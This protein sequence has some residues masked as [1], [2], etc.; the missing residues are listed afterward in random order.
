MTGAALTVACPPPAALRCPR[1]AILRLLF[2]VAS[3]L[4]GPSRTLAVSAAMSA[5]KKART[6]LDEVDDKGNFQRVEAAWRSQ[7]I[8]PGGKFE[9]EAG[10]YHLYIAL[11]CPWAAGTLTALQHKGLEDVISVSIAH[12][13][14]RRTRPDDPDDTHFG[15]WFRKP[16]DPPVSNEL[17][18]GQYECDEALI[19]DTVNH[20][21]N[22]R[23]V[24]ELASDTAGKY[25][26]PVLWCKKVRRP[27]CLGK[28]PR[29]GG[30]RACGVETKQ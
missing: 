8:E 12:P 11:G 14:W 9:P 1:A 5:A 17:G 7:P 29:G 10:R 18:F 30:S 16:G 25:S 27:P 3:A 24:Y 2:P 28:M 20:C 15:W 26:T 23:E 6:A 21:N 19:P 22:L 13:T 4:V